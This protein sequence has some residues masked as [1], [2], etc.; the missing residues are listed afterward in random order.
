MLLVKLLV[1]AILLSS[2]NSVVCNAEV[3]GA[4]TVTF[5]DE[6]D[7]YVFDADTY[8]CQDKQVVTCVIDTKGTQSVMDDE[9]IWIIK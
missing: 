2:S 6:Y 5:F 9:V 4:N 1:L 8:G 7:S 3:T